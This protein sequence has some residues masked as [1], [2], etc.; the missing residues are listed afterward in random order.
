MDQ[1]SALSS[2]SLRGLALVAASTGLLGS[3]A[4]MLYGFRRNPSVILLALFV[5]WVSS[6]FVAML[7][8]TVLAKRWTTFPHA[9]LYVVML[10]VSLGSLAL[11]ATH[12]VRPITTPFGAPFILIP[13]ASLLFAATVVGLAAVIS[14]S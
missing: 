13:P 2:G 1:V 3:L 4:L 7:L 8:T 5:I 6:P 12:V 9:I 11:Y 14:R 10:I